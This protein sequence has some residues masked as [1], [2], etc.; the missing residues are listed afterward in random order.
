M[1]IPWLSMD[2]PPSQFHL[3]LTRVIIALNND[4]MSKQNDLTDEDYAAMEEM[5]EEICGMDGYEDGGNDDE[6]E[7]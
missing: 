6:D 2:L 1:W 7:D 3:S 4:P 5:E